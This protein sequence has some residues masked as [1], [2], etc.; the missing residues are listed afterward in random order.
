MIV[1]AHNRRPFRG[2]WKAFL[3]EFAPRASIDVRSIETR[4]PVFIANSVAKMHNGKHTIILHSNIDER[5]FEE[6]GWTHDYNA[7]FMSWLFSGVSEGQPCLVL[8][9]R[10][11]LTR[12]TRPI[13]PESMSVLI[14]FSITCEPAEFTRIG[15]R[16]CSLAIGPTDNWL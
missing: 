4:R 13:Q 15:S 10:S 6:L 12:F 1:F 11:L 2:V 7:M 5:Y 9:N 3:E 8:A 16:L 14:W